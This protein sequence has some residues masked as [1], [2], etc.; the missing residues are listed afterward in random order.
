M[1]SA[2]LLG[3]P[4]NLTKE[5][6]V[7]LQEMWTATLKV[8][9][10]SGFN[11]GT[12]GDAASTTGSEVAEQAGTV[13]LEKKKKKRVTLFSRKH[14]DDAGTQEA[15]IVS[16]M[17]G[18]DKYGQTKEFHKLLESQS[19]EAIRTAFWSMVKHDDPDG[20]L[21]RFL[22][23]RKWDVQNALI[24][25]VSTMHWRMQGMHV[26]DDIVRRGEW[27]AL[28]DSAS[29]NAATKKEGRDFLTQMRLGKSFL[30]GTDK[31]GRPIT[32]VRV[33]L[34]K[35]GE[36]SD[37]SLERFTVYTIETARLL[38]SPTVDT[39][40]IV[41]DMTDFSMANMDYGP[42]KFMI[43][44]FEA[45]YPE[46]LGVVLVHKSPWIF[47]GVWK[48]IRG[49]LDPVVAGKVHFTK[50]VEELAEF[51]ER[52]HIIEELGGDDPWTY[53]YV[54]PVPEEEKLLSDGVTRQRLLDERAAVVK[55]YETATRQ[56]IHDPNST[57]ALQQKRSE[58][59]KR[60]RTGYWELDPYLRART[61]YDRTGIIREGGQIQY[62]GL[63]KSTTG[64]N[65][66]YDSIP[67]GPLPPEHR[68]DDLD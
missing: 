46:S 34:H 32:V 9:G 48:L 26:D 22:R 7:R 45:N 63:S 4:G 12:N 55:E 21:L 23:A 1:P 56:W 50:N 35:Q 11:D 57:V 58:L 39:A 8:F 10:V 17:D 37:A 13:G 64:S 27:G 6:E 43:K 3:R 68:T 51:I 30:H 5:Q 42:V 54:E 59:S 41:F 29:S 20:L 49:W 62:Y 40:A 65:A 67:H 14:H 44:V 60:L 53:Q 52:S 66:T 16:A 28:E 36:Q 33:K 25:L 31:E 19:P 2:A 38:L 18:N 24:M 61:L 15:E 47:Q